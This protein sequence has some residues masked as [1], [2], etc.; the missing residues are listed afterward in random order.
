MN[1][2]SVNS[3]SE[4]EVQSDDQRQ[5]FILRIER[6]LVVKRVS[7]RDKDGVSFWNF[8]EVLPPSSRRP[9]NE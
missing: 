2:K 8:I 5:K 1:K 3:A 7:L 9:S 4:S 6:F